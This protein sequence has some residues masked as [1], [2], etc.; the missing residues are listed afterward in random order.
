MKTLFLSLAYSSV[1]AFINRYVAGGFFER[2]QE[3]VIALIMS[4]LT[5]AEKRER[6]HAS[7][8]EEWDEVS[9]IIVNL[10]IEMVLA[11]IEFERA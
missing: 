4:D 10:A 5:G 7:I 6:V 2:V 11:R 1:R 8:A 3:L 9:S